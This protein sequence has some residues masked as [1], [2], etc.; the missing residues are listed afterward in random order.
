MALIIHFVTTIKAAFPALQNLFASGGNEETLVDR[1][2]A[3]FF[4]LL[5]DGGRTSEMRNSLPWFADV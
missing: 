3:D 5:G 4:A 1:P 2:L